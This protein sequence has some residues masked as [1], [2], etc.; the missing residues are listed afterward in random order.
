MFEKFAEEIK[1]YREFKFDR[2]DYQNRVKAMPKNYQ[3]VFNGIA[4]Y[5]WSS[6]GGS[7]VTYAITDILAMFE[8]AAKS[9]KNV[10]DITGENI[11][12]FADGV[13]H[14]LNTQH[15]VEKMK[16]DQNKAILD[17]LEK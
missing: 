11:I 3:T 16:T 12:G 9:G 10:L 1:K 14:E 15:W 17:K 2:K 13:L 7:S 4:N 5:M 6:G 8:E